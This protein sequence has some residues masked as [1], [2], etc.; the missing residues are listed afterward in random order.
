MGGEVLRREVPGSTLSDPPG[1]VRLL[2]ARAHA[3]G[4]ARREFEGKG[5]RVAEVRAALPRQEGGRA[6][7]RGGLRARGDRGVTFNL[8]GEEARRRAFSQDTPLASFGSP[9]F[10][11]FF[12]EKKKKKS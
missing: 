4:G 3:P 2:R 8:S 6:P 10:N 11:V 9:S 1:V 7:A 5:R 12:R